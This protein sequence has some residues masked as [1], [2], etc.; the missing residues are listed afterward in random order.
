MLILPKN[1]KSNNRINGK[2]FEEAFSIVAAGKYSSKNPYMKEAKIA[3]KKS[4]KYLVSSKIVKRTGNKVKAC[5]GDILIKNQSI[6]IKRVS[7]GRGTYLNTSISALEKYGAP[8]FYGQKSREYLSKFYGQEVYDKYSPLTHEQSKDFRHNHANEYKELTALDKEE[9][10]DYVT[11]VYNY[12]VNNPDICKQFFSDILNKN[13]SNKKAPDVMIV[14]NYK[15]NSTEVLT[16]DNIFSFNGEN[17]L[18]K[19]DLGLSYGNIRVQF[20]WQNGN[21]CNNPTLR[22]FLD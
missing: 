3:F 14:Y 17:K 16:K 2:L 7:S 20:G 8:A 11:T 22:V 10:K 15:K 6:E 18:K 21:G 12:F 5:N 13:I 4:K 9:R 1:S 19:T